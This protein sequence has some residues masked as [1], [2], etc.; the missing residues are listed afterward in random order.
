MFLGL[1]G[2]RYG[3]EREWIQKKEMNDDKIVT[4][5]TCFVQAKEQKMNSNYYKNN[6][7]T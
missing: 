5:I 3:I 2:L 1:V 6:F 4:F 7:V